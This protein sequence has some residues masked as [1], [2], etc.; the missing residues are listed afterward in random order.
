MSFIPSAF[1]R[2]GWPHALAALSIIGTLKYVQVHHE[3]AQKTAAEEY[4]R[5]RQANQEAEVETAR[6]EAEQEEARRKRVERRKNK[7]SNQQKV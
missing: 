2:I 1:R 4:Y 6:W 3:N 5:R 7:E